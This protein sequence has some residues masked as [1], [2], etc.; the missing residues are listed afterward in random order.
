MMGSTDELVAWGMCNRQFAFVF[1]ALLGAGTWLSCGSG[2]VPPQLSRPSGEILYLINK[3]MVTTYAVDPVSLVATE[4][5]QPVTLIAAPGSLVQ[6]D[7]A[8]DDHFVYA[9]WADGQSIQ[10]L[11]VFRTD[12]YGVPRVPAIQTLNAD[13]LSQF[14]MHPSGRFAYMLEVT[15]GNGQYQA[16][17]RL[18]HV[19]KTEGKLKESTEIQGSYGPANYWP[20]FL[21]GFSANGGN[22]YDT[23]LAATGS[24]YRQRAINLSSGTLGVDTQLLIV[25][26]EQEV[27]IGKVI[28]D[29]YQSDNS[30]YQSYLDI[31]PT[32]P[33]VTEPLIH[34]TFTMLQFCATATNVQLHPSGRYL[35]LTDPTTGEIHIAAIDLAS[36]QISDTG[37]SIP[38]TWQTPGLVFSPDRKIIY[39]ELATDK[40]VHFYQFDVS[41]GALA[42]RGTPIPTTGGICPAFYQ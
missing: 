7:P 2:G 29:Q 14:N 26:N 35:F 27:A 38:K 41:S 16:Q 4:M 20:V 22:L 25:G 5:E 19:A 36:K 1:L 28:V 11:S 9:V 32:T 42:E 34:C 21:Y 31:F 3:R 8:P 23:S 10:H 12:G 30:Q 13:S 24:V 33:N 39:A 6:F 40:S 37:N 15:S 18:F 17:I